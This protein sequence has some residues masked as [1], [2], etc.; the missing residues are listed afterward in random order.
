MAAIGLAGNVIAGVI[1][2]LA[3]LVETRRSA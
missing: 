3:G 2:G 1:S